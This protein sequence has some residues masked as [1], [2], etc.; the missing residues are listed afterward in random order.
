MILRLSM[1]LLLCGVGM[2]Q[3]QLRTIPAEA[4]RGTL[5]HL[6]AMTVALDGKPV[7]LAAG[8]QIRSEQNTIVLPTALPAGARVKYTLTP[9]GKLSRAWI[10]T[11]QEAAQPDPRK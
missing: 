2:A 10:L 11:P 8:A 5:S 7:E 9:D 3:A 6:Q 4:R 1:F